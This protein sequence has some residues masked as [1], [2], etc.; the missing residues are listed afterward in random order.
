MK[1]DVP[2]L[3]EASVIST[4]ENEGSVKITWSLPVAEDLDTILNPGPY[5][6]QLQ[7]LNG[8]DFID[9]PS[10]R[11]TST[12]F[13]S[14]IDTTFVDGDLNTRD[15]QYTY[16]VSFF[17]GQS[18]ISPYG[19]SKSASTVY[20]NAV[21][22]DQRAILNWNLKTPWSNYNYEILRRTNS[23][24]YEVIGNTNLTTFT[25]FGLDNGSQYCYIIRSEGKYG[26]N[27]LP[28]PIFNNSQ[29]SCTVPFDSVPPCNPIIS[30]TNLCEQLIDDPENPVTGNTIMWTSD[31]D[32]EDDN[33]SFNIYFAQ[34][35]S[36]DFIFLENNPASTI[37]EYFHLREGS[38]AG[39]Y[40]VTA[41]DS[42]DNESAFSN[43]VCVENCPGY[44]LPNTFTPNGDDQNDLFI[45]RVNR[46]IDEIDIQIFN[47]WGNKVF[48][49]SNPMINWDGTNMRG[50][51][52]AE[53]VYYYTCQ[54]FELSIDGTLTRIDVL[55][56]HINLIR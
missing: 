43:I 36:D 22:S 26:I 44:I 19:I 14:N 50:D 33:E 42:L 23:G 45:P 21:P 13:S 48:E 9:I 12:F 32:C 5:I 51:D 53:G 54:V 2:F 37:N 38:I 8:T 25:D 29:V 4:S 55:K 6:Y 40:A 30:V 3:T 47:Q 35:L 15:Q 10:A 39:C 20:L 11:F 28:D 7:R 16:R 24:T 31:P 34:T 18:S 17:T 52:L 56:G 46:F 27:G 49:S 1:R 41:L